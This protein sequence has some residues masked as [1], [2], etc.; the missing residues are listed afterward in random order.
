M[1]FRYNILN[2]IVRGEVRVASCAVGADPKSEVESERIIVDH[3][4]ILLAIK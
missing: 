3:V 1:P 2:R 4:G